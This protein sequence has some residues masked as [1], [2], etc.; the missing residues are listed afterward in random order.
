MNKSASTASF[1]S[2]SRGR[3]VS[4][5]TFDLRPDKLANYGHISSSFT[6]PSTG[7][8]SCRR[9]PCKSCSRTRF[10]P[11]CRTAT[12]GPARILVPLVTRTEQYDFILDTVHEARFELQREGLE[13][14]PQVP[15][16]IMLEVA[17]ATAL[18]ESWTAQ[19]DFFA[20]GT[21]DLIASV[22]GIDREHPVGAS[23]HDA[24]HPGVLRIVSQV[25][26][27]AHAAGRPVSVCGEMA[28][29]P[30]SALLLAV[31]Q[32]DSLSMAVKKLP[33]I[34]HLLSRHA[35]RDLPPLR[36]ELA[37]LRTAAQVSEFLHARILPAELEPAGVP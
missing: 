15:L 33:A 24:L 7:G 23:R 16:G 11:F 4:I 31:M 9:P 34:A 28:G 18:L 26:A 10:E 27:T 3:P 37:R 36:A 14:H 5:R 6:R 30:E 29:D 13:H 2:L 17:G 19:V 8:W 20:L 32:V 12:T 21:N 35:A 22:L 25:V 1:C